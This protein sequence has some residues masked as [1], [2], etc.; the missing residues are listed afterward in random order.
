[1]SGWRSSHWVNPSVDSCTAIDIKIL[2]KLFIWNG[3]ITSRH[4]RRLLG[5]RREEGGVGDSHRYGHIRNHH[6]LVCHPLFYSFA[7]Y[8][9]RNRGEKQ[10]ALW[11]MGLNWES[12]GCRKNEETQFGSLTRTKIWR[13]MRELC[14]RKIWSLSL[15]SWDQTQTDETNPAPHHKRVEKRA[16]WAHRVNILKRVPTLHRV[17]KW[18]LPAAF[19]R[20]QDNSHSHQHGA[21]WVPTTSVVG[22]SEWG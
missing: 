20:R 21:N 19:V 18:Y 2:K 11:R 9:W 7:R 22:S 5:R 13:G 3:N 1:M 8:Y 14:V 4:R 15:Y 17:G 10:R 6:I 12:F 16:L